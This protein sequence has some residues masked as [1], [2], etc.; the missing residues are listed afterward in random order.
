MKAILYKITSRLSSRIDT[1]KCVLLQ[2]GGANIPLRKHIWFPQ[3]GY[4]VNQF[5]HYGGNSGNP[6]G[7]WP[8]LGEALFE[9]RK[10]SPTLCD[11]CDF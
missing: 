8:F 6:L 5:C 2:V 11:Y 7:V 3:V 10:K 9:I 4:N 1:Y